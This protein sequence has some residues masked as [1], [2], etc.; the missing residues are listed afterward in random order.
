MSRADTWM[1]LYIGDYLA[2]TMSLEA[3]EHGAYLLLIM[4][5]WRNGPL[6][7]DDRALAGIARV[8][9]K[10]W[11][12]DTGPI[13]RNFFAAEDGRL[14]HKRID[15]E[16]EA[17]RLIAE[18]KRSAANARWGKDKTVST[19]TD[20]ADGSPPA[21]A[22]EDAHADAYA[23]PV[24]NVC[25]SHYARGLP[26]PSPSKKERTPH[27][28]GVAPA[29]RKSR[30]EP[31][32][33]PNETGQRKSTECGIADLE[34]EVVRFRDHHAGKGSLMADWQAAWRTWC[35][36]SQRFAKSEPRFRPGPAGALDVFG[37]S[38][39][40]SSD[41]AMTPRLRFDA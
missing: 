8:D 7:D 26:S 16:R 40:D 30:V 25:T 28:S 5:Y 39:E 13:V 27:P 23:S 2:D 1:P 29:R 12:A 34:R 35:G 32:F 31:D 37:L 33:W 24:D 18:K 10:T 15:A 41:V 38:R 20:D 19:S 22:C 36:N 6:P 11:A 21:P 14:H 4:H 9:R 17:A 3:R